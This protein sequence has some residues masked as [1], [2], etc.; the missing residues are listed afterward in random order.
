MK[1]IRKR[2]IVE[3]DWSHLADDASIPEDGNILV[4]L[5]RWRNDREALLSRSGKLGVILPNT[6]DPA[7][8]AEDLGNF[9]VVAIDFPIY[10]DG[11]GFSI[12]RLVRDR[13]GFR[14]EVRAVGNVLRDQLVFMERC[15]FDAYELQE[16]KDLENAL[17]G[18]TD[19]SVTY[20]DAIQPR[21]VPRN[22]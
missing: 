19:L 14:G 11:R 17:E 7:E 20:Q 18:F 10:R 1:I 6:T 22:P 8:L 21:S 5:E 2:T 16:G 9:A 15:G 12:G 3:D 13:L 4:P